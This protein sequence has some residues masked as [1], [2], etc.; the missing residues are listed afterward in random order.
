MINLL[1]DNPKFKDGDWVKFQEASGYVR[2]GQ[3]NK[4]YFD[5]FFFAYEE[6]TCV[7]HTP[8]WKYDLWS[9]GCSVGTGILEIRLTLATSDELLVRSLNRYGI[10]IE[11]NNFCV[12]EVNKDYYTDTIVIK[13]KLRGAGLKRE[14]C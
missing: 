2:Y 6:V 5:D 14:D 13:G 12:T 11:G 10:K 9:N 1:F 3:I 7:N 4:I 8:N